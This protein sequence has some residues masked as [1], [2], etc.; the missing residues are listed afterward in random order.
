MRSSLPGLLYLLAKHYSLERN[1]A[2]DE[3][4]DTATM[5]VKE[6]VATNPAEVLPVFNV[7]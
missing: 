7:L 5:V 3:D 2:E 1:F 4:D 6:S